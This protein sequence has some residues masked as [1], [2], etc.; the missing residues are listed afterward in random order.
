MSF[1]TSAQ[2]VSIEDAAAE[3]VRRSNQKPA[4]MVD[5]EIVGFRARSEGTNVIFEYVVAP[6]ASVAQYRRNVE[7]V[8]VRLACLENEQ[9][10]AFRRGLFYTFVYRTKDGGEL[11]TF[12]VKSATCEAILPWTRHD[13]R[14]EG[15]S[16]RYPASWKVTP[17]G[18]PNT[19]FSVASATGSGVCT[20]L[21]IADPTSAGLSQAAVNRQT[22][23]LQQD[24]AS[25]AMYLGSSVSLSA[26]LESRR[27][28][29][30]GVQALF[31]V[32][33]VQ[34]QGQRGPLRSR[35]MS[36]LAASPGK[37]W[38]LTCGSFHTDLDQ[39]RLEFDEHR[40]SFETFF[41]AF[42]LSR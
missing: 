3:V 30:A 38:V 11:A 13:D 34:M 27:T 22:E 17:K 35:M 12:S 25:W 6:R 42:S 23:E 5:D 2:G 36:A 4:A 8:V 39:A 16:V 14:E 37:V 15:F 19:R 24:V 26:L 40:A 1:S 9:N 21:R 29:I 28:S 20:V 32:A 31:G 10:E 18:S 7:Q 41:G 33:E